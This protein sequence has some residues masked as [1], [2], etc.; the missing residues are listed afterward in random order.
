MAPLVMELNKRLD[1]S[2]N[3]FFKHAEAQYF[4]AYR[5]GQAIGRISAHIDRNFNS[6][7]ATPG[8]CSVGSSVR[9]TR[10]PPVPCSTLQRSGYAS[11][12]GT[13]WSARWTSRP[14]TRSAC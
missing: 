3:P 12:A 14:T 5:D 7:R 9:T 10:R 4:L 13:A 1:Q 6:S 8:D 11:A 2:K